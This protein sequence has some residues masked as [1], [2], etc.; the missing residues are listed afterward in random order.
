MLVDID[1]NRIRPK[2]VKVRVSLPASPVGRIGASAQ[3]R[4]M[5]RSG[6]LEQAARHALE[7]EERNA[8]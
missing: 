7:A 5:S 3:K 1:F 6:F 4:R 8:T 2:S